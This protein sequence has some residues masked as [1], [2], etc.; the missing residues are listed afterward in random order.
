[1]DKAFLPRC[2]PPVAAGVLGCP[3][4]KARK[5]SGRL[6]EA[7]FGRGELAMLEN[8][9]KTPVAAGRLEHFDG[10]TRGALRVVR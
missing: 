4:L 7:D 1:M 6:R 3:F 9:E 10:E 2:Q 5:V 8:R